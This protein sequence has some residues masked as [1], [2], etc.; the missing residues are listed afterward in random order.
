M[1]KLF[2][3]LFTSEEKI[4]IYR[5]D[6]KKKKQVLID[7]KDV[8]RVVLSLHDPQFSRLLSEV[9]YSIKFKHIKFISVLLGDDDEEDDDDDEEEEEEKFIDQEAIQ[10]LLYAIKVQ[11][12]NRRPERIQVYGRNI[13]TE[14][15]RM[16][17]PFD[18]QSEQQQEEYIILFEYTSS[19]HHHHNSSLS[20]D[21]YSS[22]V[23][24]VLLY[25]EDPKFSKFLNEI[26]PEKNVKNV[27]VMFEGYSKGL[28]R[29]RIS[30]QSLNQLA[31]ALVGEHEHKIKLS[32]HNF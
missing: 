5:S 19:K 12:M 7:I 6:K 16:I 13:N 18:I 23:S 30:H 17:K 22:Q 26:L 3:S 21:S 4:L 27:F 20:K 32:Y 25:L 31:D 8:D 2:S 1:I 28:M 9:C 29:G 11:R 14:T 10:N 15:K 24:H